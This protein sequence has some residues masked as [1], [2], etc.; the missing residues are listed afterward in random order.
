MNDQLLDAIVFVFSYASNVDDWI[1][2]KKELL[3]ALPPDARTSFSIRDPKTKRQVPN[4]LE[5]LIAARWEE[6]TGRQVLFR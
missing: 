1:T 4:E 5:K 2:I 6:M 3:K